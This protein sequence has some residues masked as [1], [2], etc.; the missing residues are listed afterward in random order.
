MAAAYDGADDAIQIL[1]SHGAN[2][3]KV[4]KTGNTALE[5]AI[6]KKLTQTSLLLLARTKVTG[7]RAARILRQ[8]CRFGLET[9]ANM[10]LDN[11]RNFDEVR[12][13][14]IMTLPMVPI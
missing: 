12:Q 11:I 6:Q 7:E 3:D 5:A 14:E 8:I 10:F 9:V 2:P 13:R 4:E 1:L